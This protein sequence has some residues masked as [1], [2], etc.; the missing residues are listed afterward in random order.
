MAKVEFIAPTKD[1]GPEYILRPQSVEEQR[2]LTI[3]RDRSIEGKVFLR[4]T[5]AE[6][7]E[8]NILGLPD[9]PVVA[10]RL[11]LVNAKG[12]PLTIPVD[13]PLDPNKFVKMEANPGRLAGVGTGKGT[14]KVTRISDERSVIE[15]R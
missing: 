9:R 5:G 15:I 14:M 12:E 7:S 13:A 4:V 3:W 6:Y 8:K 2:L 10:L 1:T 11:E